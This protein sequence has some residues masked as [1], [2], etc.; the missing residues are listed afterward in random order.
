MP[1]HARGRWLAGRARAR[2]VLAAAALA[3]LGLAGLPAAGPAATVLAATAASRPHH[4]VF[5]VDG[6]D[7]AAVPAVPA[8]AQF[9]GTPRIAPAGSGLEQ[10]C[11]TPVR[12]GQ[13]ACMALLARNGRH[14]SFDASAPTGYTAQDLWSAY[15]LTS[16]ES[17]TASGETIAVVDAYNDPNAASDLAVY[18]SK[19]NLPAMSCSS[20]SAPCLTVVNEYGGSKLPKS[21]PSGGWELEESVDLDM[22]SAICP[23]CSIVLLE[24]NSANISDLAT[25]ERTA[26]KGPE[27]DVVSD[28][29]GSGAEFI[30]E[31]QY[32]QDFYAPGVAIAA[33]GGDDGYGT[34][35]PAASPYVTS[36]GGTSLS[37]TGTA[38]TQTAWNSVGSGCSALEPKP[39]W[40]TKDD[41]SPRGC[42]NRTMNDVSADADPDTPV[43]I[44]DTVRDPSL[45]GAP[46]WTNVGG[47]SVATPI[48]AGTYALA[49]IVAGGQG[50]AL[51]QG[52]FPAAYPYQ[53][54]S[55][56]TPVTTGSNGNCESD[57]RYLCNAGSGY[58]GPAGLGT[59]DGVAAFTG[60]SA[61]EV[62][63][64]DP[65]PQIVQ[66]N[67]KVN[68]TL[69]YLPGTESPTYSTTPSVLPG[70]LYV[71]GQDGVLSGTAPAKAGVYR[72]TVTASVSGVGTG[73]TTFSLVVLPGMKVA[74]PGLG[75]VRLDG[76]DHC[77]TQ[78]GSAA[79]VESCTGGAD[80]QWE[81]M[82]SG[83]SG[84]GELRHAG[85][86]LE[87]KTGTGNGADATLQA[88]GKAA[89]EQWS[90]AGSDR[91][92]N[93]V[94]GKCLD[95]HGS[96]TAG[97]K[98][99]EWTCSASGGTS[100]VLPAAP[101][102]S[103]IAD[104]CLSDPGV[105]SAGG[106]KIELS[107]CSSAGGQ[108]WTAHQNGTIVIAGKCLAVAGSS[109][110]DGAAVE[111]AT[112]TGQTAQK[113]LRGPNGQLM[114]A[115]SSRCLDDPGDSAQ[116][117]TR[118]VQDDCYSL[119]GEVWMVS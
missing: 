14:A 87:V 104:R 32:D 94:T 86:C 107:A 49:D 31:N 40:Q 35:Y 58:N 92:H 7:A 11:A 43:A 56:L 38:W 99:V 68:L 20:S 61:G 74:H 98:A 73:S 55:G 57:R 103:G 78:A 113:W 67:A 102:L 51:I 84:T 101:V 112:C 65:G 37:D 82:P 79:K 90:Y 6:A 45:G 77:L 53:A 88:C 34:Q 80:Q 26:D 69:D 19:M 23:N 28:S 85:K 100:W 29:W 110:F 44:Y 30:G 2:V 76:A 72:I 18:R 13:M 116:S 71:N 70:S 27:V 75:E 4:V 8:T 9:V 117:G 119:P 50:D 46:D 36:V 95:I 108:R 1:V 96:V 115:N 52:T 59:P 48:I 118:L 63:V 64:A 42:L 111:L 114:N 39:P 15:G 17:K 91:L 105:S 60:P 22:V 93:A 41:S 106:T 5:A 24:A 25:A 109:M 10:A 89:R 33:A 3:G 97:K 62:T 83:T 47:T 54:K 21:D 16:D 81:F 66:E 12:P